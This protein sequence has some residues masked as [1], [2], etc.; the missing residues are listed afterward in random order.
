MRHHF[1]HLRTILMKRISQKEGDS[2]RRYAWIAGI[3]IFVCLMTACQSRTTP[4]T[5]TFTVTYDR[6]YDDRAEATIVE[7]R[8]RLSPD[9]PLRKGYVFDGWYYYEEEARVPPSLFCGE[10]TRTPWR[11]TWFCMREGSPSSIRFILMPTA[12]CARWRRHSQP[13]RAVRQ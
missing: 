8:T 6:G 10:R 7:A 5:V 4:Q 1:A 2:M 9:E 3:L 13:L 11:G 12:E